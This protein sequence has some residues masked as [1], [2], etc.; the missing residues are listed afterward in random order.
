M[1]VVP[2]NNAIFYRHQF[3]NTVVNIW[4]WTPGGNVSSRF[5]SNSEAFASELLSWRHLSSRMITWV[6]EI[7][8]CMHVF[9]KKLI[10]QIPMSHLFIISTTISTT[11][12]QIVNL[13]LYISSYRLFLYLIL[14][15]CNTIPQKNS[16]L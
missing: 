15:L 2:C 16:T 14:I 3:A 7:N 13:S 9:A 6:S 12:H 1:H 8:D 5:P 11:R 4:Y 10:R